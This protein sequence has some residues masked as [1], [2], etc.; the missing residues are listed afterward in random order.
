MIISR[1][2]G[3]FEVGFMPAGIT[4]IQYGKIAVCKWGGDIV[5]LFTQTGQKVTD[6]HGPLGTHAFDIDS[7]DT[8]IFV[9]DRQTNSVLVFDQEQLVNTNDINSIRMISGISISNN[10]MYVTGGESNNV[11][12]F[13]IV[14]GTTLSRQRQFSAGIQLKTPAF[15]CVQGDMAI[16]CHTDHC[17]NCLDSNGKTKFT[18][19]KAGRLGSSPNQ[20]Y[21]PWGVTM[22]HNNILLI[23]DNGNH[24]VSM[25]SDEGLGF[26]WVTLTSTN[27]V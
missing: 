10:T 16:S 5:R 21:Y 17:V 2:L 6:L 7:N 3:Q 11:Y 22:D 18:F 8:H 20:L 27:M 1:K 19:G 24:R 12:M 9:T 25:V 4:C 14:D 15:V 26:C 23:S 13:D